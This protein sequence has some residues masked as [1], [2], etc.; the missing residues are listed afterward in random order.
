[1]LVSE[2]KGKAIVLLTEEMDVFHLEEPCNFI[3]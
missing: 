2:N 1:M 3:C